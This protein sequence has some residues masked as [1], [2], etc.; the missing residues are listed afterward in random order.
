MTVTARALPLLALVAAVA[1]A[2]SES[3][4]RCGDSL[5]KLD[6]LLGDVSESDHGYNAR[7]LASSIASNAASGL[8]DFVTRLVNSMPTDDDDDPSDPIVQP[9]RL[10][11]YVDDNDVKAKCDDARS[12]KFMQGAG[13]AACDLLTSVTNLEGM[14]K[15]LTSL[16]QADLDGARDHVRDL[17]SQAAQRFRDAVGSGVYTPPNGWSVSNIGSMEELAKLAAEGLFWGSSGGGGSG[18][19]W[20]LT[21]VEDR[22]SKDDDGDDDWS[23]GFR[24]LWSG[25]GGG[26]AGFSSPYHGEPS[27]VGGGGGGGALAGKYLMGV[28]AGTNGDGAYAAR[29]LSLSLSLCV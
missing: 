21:C 4:V 20:Q 11:F 22:P 2:H 15:F 12:G 28:G 16:I 3:N 18:F 14:G 1:V 25:G 23:P 17:G 24:T 5:D 19:G 7:D 8:V 9:L 26:G 29:S 6:D 13:G 10:A 27:R